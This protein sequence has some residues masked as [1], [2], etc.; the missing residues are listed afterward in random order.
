MVKPLYIGIV[1]VLL[2]AI[3]GGALVLSKR[4]NSEVSTQTAV[5]TTSPMNPSAE[6]PRTIKELLTYTGTQQCSFSTEG[7]T[8]QVYM[9]GGKMRGD[10]TITIPQGNTDSHMI[11]DGQTVYIWSENQTNG[12]K[13]TSDVIGEFDTPNQAA[14]IDPNQDMNFSCSS[15]TVN[16][17]IFVPPTSITFAELDSSLK[18]DGNAP[19]SISCSTCDTMP[20]S[21]R[22]DCRAA[23]CN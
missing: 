10:F 13:I 6:A 23:L 5:E 14:V 2:L 3:G 12:L 11:V 15:W 19:P 8:G 20:E 4:N 17:S 16:Q 21:A 22:A 9:S 1:V 7:N 18:V